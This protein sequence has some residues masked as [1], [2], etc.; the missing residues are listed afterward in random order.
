[1][2]TRRTHTISSKTI[3][4]VLL[5][6]AP[7]NGGQRNSQRQ[8]EQGLSLIECLVAIV[9]IG[10][11]IFAITPPL[12]LA[13]G[14][15]IQSRRAEQANHIAQSEVDRIR[16]LV[17]RGGYS[18]NDLPADAGNVSIASVPAAG[19]STAGSYL[20]SSS[21]CSS[22]NTLYPQA[23]P[24][25]INKLVLVDVNGDCTPEYVMQ[26]FRNS[27]KVATSAAA[28]SPP[29][30]FD[31]GVRVYNYFSGQALP[32]LLVDQRASLVAGTNTR[33]T[34]NAGRRPLAVLY[35]RMTRNDQS[36]AL[37]ALCGQAGGNCNY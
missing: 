6:L 16:L 37:G 24:V 32:T 25:A 29:T 26:V 10:L 27:G 14:T 8:S 20:L 17:E 7:L 18:A 2:Q 1:M 9:I 21:N 28:G 11:T 19:S 33:D 4:N 30:S 22:G 3:L 5:N 23:T 13:A 34:I 31:V 15:R 12:L 36:G 35:S